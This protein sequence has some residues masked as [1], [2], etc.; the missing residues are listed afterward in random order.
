MTNLHF[1]AP[2]GGTAATFS[3]EWWYRLEQSKHGTNTV[4]TICTIKKNG[5][6]FIEESIVKSYKDS[7]VKAVARKISLRKALS[8]VGEKATR[9]A[10]WH[11]YHGRYNSVSVEPAAQT[12]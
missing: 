8:R 7:H 12:V 3:L 11:A 1:I 4:R 2:L 10:I 6:A 5:K 9:T